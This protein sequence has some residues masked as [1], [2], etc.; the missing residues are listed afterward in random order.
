M[1]RARGTRWLRTI[2]RF[3]ACAAACLVLAACSS[4]AK[5]DGTTRVE[6]TK[7][8]TMSG[9]ANT[10]IGLETPSTATA[11]D[12]TPG[13][14][15][16]AWESM[17]TWTHAWV[18]DGGDLANILLCTPIRCQKCGAVRHECARKSGR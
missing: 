10:P 13:K 11:E 16:H 9:T 1:G 4:G 7:V 6:R 2:A 14:C 17:A 3:V 12:E 5:D 15:R 18:D 8:A